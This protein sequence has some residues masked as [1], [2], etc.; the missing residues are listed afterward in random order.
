MPHVTG[1]YSFLADLIVTFHLFYVIFAVGGQIVILAGLWL[2]WRFVRQPAF[3]IAH[4]IAV[5]FVAFEAVIGMVCPLTE[6][7]NNLR[8]L[9]GQSVDTDISFIARLV[10]KVIFYDFPPWVFSVM[11][12]F[13]GLVVIMTF[14]FAP[15]RFRKKERT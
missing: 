6:W 3:R 2:K 7:E 10:R 13:F 9:A 8:Q 4:L 15:P 1:G 5:A 12:I 11:H 14:V